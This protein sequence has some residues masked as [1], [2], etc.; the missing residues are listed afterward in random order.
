MSPVSRPPC[1]RAALAV[2]FAAATVAAGGCT[3]ANSSH[4]GYDPNTL[5]VVLSQEPPTLEPCESSLTSTGIVVRSNITEPLIERDPNSG[6]LQPLLATEWRQASPNQWVFKVRDGVTF[7]NGAPFTAKD[8]AFSID[9]AVNSELQCNVDGYVFGDEKLKLSTPDDNTVV[10]GTEKPDPILPLRISFVE[11]VP[12]TTSTTEKVREPIGTGPYAIEDWEYG[13]KLL[14]KRNDTYWGKKPAFARAEYQWRSE[15]SVRAAMITNDETD[16][17]TSLGPEDGA[18][19]RGVPF[20]NNETT[21]LRMQATE[22]PLND[23]RVRQAINY[24][25]NRTGIVNALFRG[26]GQPAA[27][28][29]PSGVVGYNDQLQLWPHDPEKAKQLIATAKADGVPVDK[30]IRLI[31]RTAQFPN[32]AETIEVLQSEFSEIGLNVKIEM[33]DTS[34]QLLYQLRPFPQNPGP[35]LLMI[36]HGNQAGDAAFTMDQY[37]LSEGPQA[38][39]GTTEFDEK[40]RAAEVLTGEARQDAFAKLFAEEPQELMQMAYIAHMKGILGKSPRVDYTPNSATGDE[41][42]LAEMT[43]AAD[44]TDKS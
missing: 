9:R 16:I 44:R 26:L 43:P 21:A 10:V 41:M 28:L 30:Q 24:A 19:E 3:V 42:R 39:Y 6:D 34:N 33:M 14:L 40:I 38:A 31:G 15:G 11:I 5:R 2:A 27:Q 12:T 8:A 36:M 13:Q 25:V 17:A 20:Q 4:G 35:Y 1:R 29:I 22:A 32:I 23:I 37:M 7:S 18:G